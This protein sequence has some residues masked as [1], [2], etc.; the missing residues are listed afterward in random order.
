MDN[1]FNDLDAGLKVSNTFPSNTFLRD[2]STD[3]LKLIF[4]APVKPAI[5]LHPRVNRLASP[6]YARSARVAD[7][8]RRVLQ[9][10]GYSNQAGTPTKRKNARAM[11]SKEWFVWDYGEY[12]GARAGGSRYWGCH[13][14]TELLQVT[15]LLQ[16][17]ASAGGSSLSFPTER[18]HSAKAMPSLNKQVVNPVV[19]QS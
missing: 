1:E 3:I 9:P 4:A 2:G 7:A 19:K 12:L 16:A 14:F 10:S 8:L 6:T 18:K 11:E 15:E 17:K 13:H 5:I